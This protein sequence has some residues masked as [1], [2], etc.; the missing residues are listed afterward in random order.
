MSS[1]RMQLCGSNHTYQI[2]FR[3]LV[4][5]LPVSCGEPQGSVLGPLLFLAININ[6]MQ[7]CELL[8]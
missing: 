6:E 7:E 4:D 5:G 1:T 3:V 2:A 8:M